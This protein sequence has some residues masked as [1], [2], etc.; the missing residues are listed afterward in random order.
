[1]KVFWGEDGDGRTHRKEKGNEGR[2]CTGR[3]R[4]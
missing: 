4:K 2:R 1:M 3:R